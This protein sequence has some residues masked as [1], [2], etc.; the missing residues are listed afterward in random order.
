KRGACY[1][2]ID[3]PEQA[4]ADFD[5]V[6]KHSLQFARAFVVDHLSPG[7]FSQGPSR[8][9]FAENWG[10]RG[11]ALLMLGRDQD[12]LESFQQAVSLFSLPEDSGNKP[13][14]AAAY[15]GLGQAYHRLGQDGPAAGAY[16]QAIA[17]YPTDPNA[18]AGRGDV[19]AAQRLFDQALADYT[20]AIR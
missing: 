20:E 15:Q 1:L 6:N 13:G 14:R 3:Q 19:L 8:L 16:N 9:D 2:R 4:L 18:F 12:A 17:I 10:N 5:R 7:G 11:I